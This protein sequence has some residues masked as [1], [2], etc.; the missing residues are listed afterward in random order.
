[1]RFRRPLLKLSGEALMGDG[2]YGI[3][4][5]ALAGYAGEIAQV[6]ALGVRLSI[7]VGGG[8]IYRGLAGAASGMDRVTAD[9]MG[10]LATVI[11]ALALREGLAEAGVDA[12][13]YSGLSMPSVC[14]TFRRDAARADLDAGRIVIFG[15]GTG[16]PFFTTDTAAALRAAELGCDAL[17]KATAVDGVY[18]ADPRKY[19]DARRYDS[20]SYDRALAEKL[21]VMDAAAFAI[22]RDSGVPIVVFSLSK[23]GNIAKVFTGE[24]PFTLVHGG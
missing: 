19:P 14:P 7:V 10:M 13:V 24:A 21:E 1:L 12:V 8:N 17:L 4:A 3:D 16:N 5:T 11:N 23:P 9:Q 15:G 20:L 18:S 22:A 2:A 6:A